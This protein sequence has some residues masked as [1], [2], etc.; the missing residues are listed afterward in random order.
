[1]LDPD[2]IDNHRLFL[3]YAE[4]TVDGGAIF[5]NRVVRYSWDGSQLVDPRLILD[6]PDFG[7]NEIGGIVNFGH[8]DK[9]YTL[10]GAMERS[11]KLQN[12][13]AG[14]DPDDSS[15]ILRTHADGSG[16]PGN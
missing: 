1:A 9:L 4:S 14:P 7:A 13:A 11:G 5:A 10:V 12:V 2:F 15:V 16:V 3:Y 6:F 8:D